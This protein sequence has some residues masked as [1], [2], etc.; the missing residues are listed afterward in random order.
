MPLGLER[1]GR[2]VE[3]AV[4]GGDHA[5]LRAVH[6]HPHAAE[7]GFELVAQRAD[8]VGADEADA[9]AEHFGMDGV[10]DERADRLAGRA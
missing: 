3:E 8:E 9:V 1:I 6:E 10:V 5:A 4:V 7:V 2:L